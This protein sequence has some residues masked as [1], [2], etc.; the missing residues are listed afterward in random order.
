MKFRE[1]ALSITAVLATAL[2]IFALA[3]ASPVTSDALAE[4]SAGGGPCPRDTVGD[5]LTDPI[6][7]VSPDDGSILD[8]LLEVLDEIF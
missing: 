1:S 8:E 6:E 2:L 5:T 7:S 4:G 3:S